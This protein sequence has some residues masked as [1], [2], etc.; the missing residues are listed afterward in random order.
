MYFVSIMHFVIYSFRLFNL[1]PGYWLKHDSVFFEYVGNISQHFIAMHR[2]VL[3]PVM[4]RKIRM[5]ILMTSNQTPTFADDYVRIVT[6]RALIHL[7]A[8]DISTKFEDISYIRFGA[9]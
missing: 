1:L 6:K 7:Y 8:T 3:V 5:V 9:D 4:R 2:L